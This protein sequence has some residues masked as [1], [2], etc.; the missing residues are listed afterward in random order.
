LAAEKNTT[1]NLYLM[2]LN[3]TELRKVCIWRFQI[4]FGLNSIKMR[5]I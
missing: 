4:L 5:Q 3:G 2:N 1:D